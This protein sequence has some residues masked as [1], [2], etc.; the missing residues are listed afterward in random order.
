MANDSTRDISCVA[1]KRL[2]LSAV[3]IDLDGFVYNLKKFIHF[4]YSKDRV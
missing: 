4:L 3:I 2:I 1:R